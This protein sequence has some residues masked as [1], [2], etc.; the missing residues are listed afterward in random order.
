MEELLKEL[1]YTNEQINAIVDG[2][3]NKKIF[4]FGVKNIT[5]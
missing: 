1:G 5:I 2:M 3:K 4:T